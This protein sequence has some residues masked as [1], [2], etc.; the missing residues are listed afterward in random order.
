MMDVGGATT[1][2]SAIPKHVDLSCI[3]K[4][5]EQTMKLFYGLCLMP[6]SR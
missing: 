4:Q 2:G 5:A 3:R 6:A 1:A